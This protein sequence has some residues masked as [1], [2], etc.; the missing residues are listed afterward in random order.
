[1]LWGISKQGYRCKTCGFTCHFQCTNKVVTT[2]KVHSY[3]P[4]TTHHD[5]KTT[6]FM[7]PTYCNI[8]RNLLYGVKNQGQK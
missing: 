2:C 1:M 8:C 4:P 5:F 3:V 7:Q 6:T